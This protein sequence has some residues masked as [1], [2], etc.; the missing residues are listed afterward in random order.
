MAL[1]ALAGSLIAQPMPAAA[2]DLVEA[3]KRMRQSVVAVGTYQELRQPP[4][5]LLGTGFTVANGHYVITNHHVIPE[6]LDIENDEYLE[7]F[8]GIEANVRRYRVEVISF[9]DIHDLSLLRLVD[10]RLEPIA[11]AKTDAKE[12]QRV[13]ITG[14]PLGSLL[15]LYPITH[16]G[17][18]SAIKERSFAAYNPGQL[19]AERIR[20]LRNRFKVYQVDANAYPGNSG[21]PLYDPVTLQV[22]GVVQ[23]VA[24]REKTQ[25]S[26]IESPTGFT[27]AVPSRFVS[28]LL[29]RNNLPGY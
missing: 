7:V 24:V 26:A 14:Y 28:A 12:G 27:Y 10:G 16:E 17:I 13:A 6:K 3:I 1:L 20:R 9:D 21:S 2:A 19:T 23:S 11:I 25:Q 22:V 4:I 29:A 15:G 5:R 18:I 8:S